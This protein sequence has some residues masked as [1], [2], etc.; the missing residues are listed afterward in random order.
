MKLRKKVLGLLM[1]CCVGLTAVACTQSSVEENQVIASTA[2]GTA[3][4]NDEQ[5]MDAALPTASG[6]VEFIEAGEVFEQ[7]VMKGDSNYFIVDLR[8]TEDFLAASIQGSIRIPADVTSRDEVIR[9]LPQDKKIILVDYDGSFAGQTAATW[10]SL[11]LDTAVL[12]NGMEGWNGYPTVETEL[13]ETASS[14]CS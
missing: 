8:D 4:E 12:V 10:Q 1:V 2:A 9:L 3:T 11:G 6:E 7:V 13:S 14:G 5:A